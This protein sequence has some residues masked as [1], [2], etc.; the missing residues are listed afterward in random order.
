MTLSPGDR[1]GPH[2]IRSHIGAGGMGD[3]Y[4]AR[5]TRLG[6]DVAIK[7]STAE[8]TER[9][10]SEAR[11][12][13]ALNYPT[14]CTLYDVGPNYLVMEYVEGETLAEKLAGRSGRGLPMEEALT[15]ARQIALALEHAH[16]L[17]IVHR[18]LKPA[19]IKVKPDGTVK[20]LDFGLAKIVGSTTAQTENS[21]TIS[22]AATLA[23]VIQGTAGYMS[24]EQ[25]RGKAVDK[26]ADIWAFGVVVYEL[27][28]GERLF[29]GEDIGEILAAVIKEEPRLDRVP[30]RVRP[31]LHRCLEKDPRK[32]LRDIGDIGLLLEEGPQAAEPRRASWFWPAA[33]ALLLTIASGLAVLY[34][35][36]TPRAQQALRFQI[37]P[38]GNAEAEM[39][40]LSPDGRYLAFIASDDGPSKLWL[41][42]MDA[43]DSR[44]VAGTEGASFPFW[45]PDGQDLGFFAEGKL[46]K[47][48][49]AGG[50]SQTL[51][52]AA[53]GRGGTW[54]RDGVILFSA[55][56][57]SPILRVSSAG[58]APTPVT[59][60]GGG[61][62]AEGHR[63]PAFLP[64]GRH[65]LYNVGSNKPD[66]SGLFL[67][68][69]DGAAPVKLLPDVTNALYASP[70]V[71][72]GSGLLLFR[73]EGTLMAQP[74]DASGLRTT[75][76]VLPI[77]EQV[78]L[79]ANGLNTF[80]AFSMAPNGTL[81]YRT[82][83]PAANRELVWVD[84]IGRRV[85]TETKPAAIENPYSL[86]PDEKT[87]TVSIGA[88]SNSDLWLQ[89]VERGVLTRY[90]FRA[91][92]NRNP[93]WSPD[94]SQLIF[95]TIDVGGYSYDI[96]RESTSGGGKVELLLHADRNLLTTD[97]S[98][99]GKLIAYQQPVPVTGWN[100]WLLPLDGDR[101]PVPYL[102]TAFDEQNARFS[103]GPAGGPRWMAYQ[104]NESGRNQIYIQAI[105]ASGAKYQ[106]STTGGTIPRWRQDARE[107]FYLSA[108]RKLM[109]TP[110]SLGAH[111][112]IGTPQEA[113][114]IAGMTSF[115]PSRDG[116]RFLVNVPAGGGT[117]ATP[118]T[119]VTN[120]QATLKK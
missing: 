44:A 81:V 62:D 116:Q 23:G 61:A 93:I 18:D 45:S 75:G 54:N 78:A 104:S 39:F 64:D 2:E 59:D 117:A 108:D 114:T 87:L 13:A 90:T 97:W 68:S 47:I 26:R 10:Q 1:L 105:P 21:P 17:G 98:P 95:S 74:F 53:N 22:M 46:K 20:V 28:T 24:P 73:R 63:Y 65:F 89:D 71:P 16:E 55:G 67:G 37:P 52:D 49:M 100:L 83:G 96:Y 3:V 14:I 50:P 7:V 66:A 31:L 111:P 25:A 80:G 38:P 36:Q 94:G 120:W 99:D 51:S 5:D 69:L 58:G 91:G 82:G 86:S 4:R 106:V 70:A 35:R 102:Q 41:R 34:L 42:A 88:G 79:G 113:F 48:A 118:I 101:K 40:T 30:A 107:L 19:N 103:P 76:E 115:V 110:T 85:R 109:A 77:A 12:I 60:L 15:L 33:A 6:R 119:V 92:T 43:L 8:F 72:G 84:R 56:P 29:K 11:A 112:Q 32:R 57:T 9:F 27:L